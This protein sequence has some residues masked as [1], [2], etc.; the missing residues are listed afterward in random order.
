VA[1]DLRFPRRHLL[2]IGRNKASLSAILQGAVSVVVL[3]MV[4]LWAGAA[5]EERLMGVQGLHSSLR[6]VMA[7]M[8]RALLIV[9]AVLVSLSRWAST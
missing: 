8:S 2:P 1:A 9:V 4:A 6:V 5:L 3:L 7:R